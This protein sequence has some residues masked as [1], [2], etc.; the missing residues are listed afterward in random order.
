MVQDFRRATQRHP[1]TI[2]QRPQQRLVA[3]RILQASFVRCRQSQAGIVGVELLAR[4][5]AT[6][7]RDQ[8]DRHREQQRRVFRSVTAFAALR[9]G[10]LSPRRN[11]RKGPDG[12]PSAG[13]VTE[14]PTSVHL[15]NKSH[16]LVLGENDVSSAIQSRPAR[17]LTTMHSRPA[18]TRSCSQS[19]RCCQPLS[20]VAAGKCTAAS[21]D[22]VIVGEWDL[23]VAVGAG[24]RTNPI[25]GRGDIPIIVIP[26][27]SYYGKRFFLDNLEPGLTLFEGESNTVNLS[28]RPATI[29]VFFSP[30]RSAERIRE[31]PVGLDCGGSSIVDD[32]AVDPG[33]GCHEY[34]GHPPT[35][36]LS[37]RTRV[38]VLARPVRRTT[39]RSAGS[40]RSARRLRNPWRASA[41]LIQ[42]EN[43]LVVNAGFTLK[44]AEHRGLLLWGERALSCR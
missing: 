31:R 42:T 15:R 2:A 38:A 29:A 33:T 7:A 11:T 37:G 20:A 26:Q 3:R 43:S 6:A 9:T 12:N 22:C 23:S 16:P 18:H 34:R 30:Q 5:R 10:L 39:E 35:H 32:P 13:F 36:D 41:P 17:R 1:Q 40:H 21:A 44:S 27:L 14:H 28:P 4:A 19:S 24:V 8:A 25:V